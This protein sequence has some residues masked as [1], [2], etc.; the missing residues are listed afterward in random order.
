MLRNGI[1]DQT[2]FTSIT[3][4]ETEK[5]SWKLLLSHHQRVQHLTAELAWEIKLTL[6]FNNEYIKRVWLKDTKEWLT[7]NRTLCVRENNQ[8]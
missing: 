7:L 2:G 4:L 3:F 6:L 1:W 8:V 5:P